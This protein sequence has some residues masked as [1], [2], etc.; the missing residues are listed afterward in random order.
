MRYHIILLL[1]V[2]FIPIF[3]THA[4]TRDAE[5]EAILKQISAPLL[6]AANLKECPIYLVKNRSLNAYTTFGPSIFVYSG[7]MTWNDDPSVVIGVL[8]HEIG[9][10]RSNHVIEKIDS[11]RQAMNASVTG[12][13][14]GLLAAILG[15]PQIGTAIGAAG[16]GIGQ[17]KFLSYS[18][19]Q[20]RIADILAVQYLSAAKYPISG[21]IKLM[22]EF[23]KIDTQK[24]K[25]NQ[26]V[27]THPMSQERLDFFMSRAKDT[28]TSIK[29]KILQN[30]RFATYKIRAVENP[31]AFST[32][33]LNDW[34]NYAH[35]V[36]LIRNGN[37]HSAIKILDSLI[38]KYPDYPYFYVTKAH[39]LRKYGRL[40]QSALMYDKALHLTPNNEILMI[41]YADELIEIANKKTLTDAKRILTSMR[42]LYAKNAQ[43]Y[44]LLGKLFAKQDN[45]HQSYLELS[46]Y[47]KMTHNVEMSQHFLSLAKKITS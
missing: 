42:I 10:A 4:E 38:H 34:E 8:A 31:D 15:A 26:Y 23:S 12:I 11:F 13:G 33:G 18:R 45:L 20:E 1:I 21:I 16:T 14:F 36:Y 32:F 5:S 35:V 41:E 27:R 43:T 46:Q 39:I 24:S 19:N 17:D 3:F 28:N 22:Q 25:Q 29:P 40:Y 6:K 37:I 9:H 7:L 44:Y 30:Y 2:Q 47:Y